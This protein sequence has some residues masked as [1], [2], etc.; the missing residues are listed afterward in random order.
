MSRRSIG[1]LLLLLCSSALGIGIGHWFSGVFDATVPAAVLTQ[2]NHAAAYTYF[3][4]RGFLVGLVVF[5]FSLLVLLVS[6]LFAADAGDS[7]L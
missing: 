3:L 7:D 5:V 2:F 1:L 6:R 4:F